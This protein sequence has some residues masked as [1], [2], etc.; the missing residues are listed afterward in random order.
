MTN[1]VF[2]C[3]YEPGDSGTWLSW[4]IN[5]HVGYPKFDKKIRYERKGYTYGQIATDY[6]CPGSNWH[7]A[8]F[9]SFRDDPMDP[10]SN[11][12][13]T[14][15]NF[16]DYKKHLIEKDIKHDP[17]YKN[18]CYKILP[19]HNPIHTGNKGSQEIEK[20]GLKDKTAKD[21]ILRILEESNTKAIII[22]E[23]DIYSSLFAKRLAFIRPN[24]TVQDAWQD[25]NTRKKTLYAEIVSN[26]SKYV[27]VHTLFIDKLILKNDINEYSKLLDILQVPELENWTNYTTECCNTI[28]E[29]WTNFT[30]DQ[31]DNRP[32][33]R[34]IK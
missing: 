30:N 32:E 13:V 15:H 19:W 9:Q 12:L 10:Y 16:K 20:W 5:Q 14:T 2:G 31:L 26:V 11:K 6:A 1:D 8:N 24:L 4:F 7:L 33:T 29:P 25:Y 28:F 3:W 34:D 17:D 27:K 23:T 21:L 22:P 18:I